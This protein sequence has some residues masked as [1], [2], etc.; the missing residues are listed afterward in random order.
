MA[1]IFL[2]TNSVIA[3]EM[4]PVSIR[5]I[6]LGGAYCAIADDLG[7]ATSNPAG[8][9]KSNYWQIGTSYTNVL[10]QD[11]DFSWFGIITPPTRIGN[12]AIS[13]SSLADSVFGYKEEW[14]SFAVGKN[15]YFNTYLGLCYTDFTLVSFE[16]AR[17]QEVLCGFLYTPAPWKVGLAVKTNSLKFRDG[18]LESSSRATLG[19]AYEVK[20]KTVVADLDSNK[21]WRV[22]LERKLNEQIAVRCGLTQW[23]W[24]FG[25]GIQEG[26]WQ[27]DYAYCNN[28]IGN[29]H[30]IGMK[31]RF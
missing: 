24:T 3:L 29:E 13:Y 23:K 18:T 8:L 7:F 2:V 20:D 25:F 11:I 12:M 21:E 4:Q 26:C 27:L 5:A 19:L 16:Q 31:R 28:D 6:A 15:V 22:G 9:A 30:Q 17:G 10:N 1:I 14:K